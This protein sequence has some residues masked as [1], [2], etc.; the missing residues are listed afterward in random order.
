[1]SARVTLY[2]GAQILFPDGPR[3]VVAVS[4]LGYSVRDVTGTVTEVSWTTVQPART[5]LDGRVDAVAESVM[6]VLQGLSDS[7]LQEALDKQEVVLTMRT[8]YA[9]GDAAVARPG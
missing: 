8:G 2:E 9:R 4:P 7:A 5:I 6:A 1:M 3:T